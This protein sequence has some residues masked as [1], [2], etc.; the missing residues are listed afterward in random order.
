[1]GETIMKI[2]MLIETK[3][4]SDLYTV[5]TQQNI[6]PVSTL[7]E[8]L[9]WCKYTARTKQKSLANSTLQQIRKDNK[10]VGYKV[11]KDTDTYA[12]TFEEHTLDL[13]TTCD[14]TQ[15]T[16]TYPKLSNDLEV[17]QAYDHITECHNC[18]VWAWETLHVGGN[19]DLQQKINK[20][21]GG[22]P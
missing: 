12:Y 9:T 20:L 4:I 18:Q 13:T 14:K 5:I 16:L 21:R 19:F 15:K 6:K 11:T 3:R 7:T 2:Y 17:A 10:I 22:A 8:A 1:M